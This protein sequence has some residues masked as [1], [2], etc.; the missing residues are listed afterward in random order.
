MRAFVYH[1]AEPTVCYLPPIEFITLGGPV[2]FQD[3]SLLSRYF[4]TDTPGRAKT[5]RDLVWLAEK[6]RD[7]DLALSNEIVESQKAVRTLYQPEYVWPIF[8]RAMAEMLGSAGDD[9]ATNLFYVPRKPTAKRI[10]STAKRGDGE[11]RQSLLFYGFGPLIVRRDGKYHCSEGIARV[12]RQFVRALADKKFTVIVTSREPD[13]ARVYGFLASGVE[14][15]TKLKIL[16]V[17]AVEDTGAKGLRSLIVDH[18]DV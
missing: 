10:A 13:V 6:L 2:I 9:A 18:L 3:G 14:D 11:G 7:G 1:Y 8:D 5:T 17:D 15:V 12:V 4:E 16:N